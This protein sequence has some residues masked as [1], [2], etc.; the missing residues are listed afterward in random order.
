MAAID[1][2]ET[3]HRNAAPSRGETWWKGVEHLRELG[4]NIPKLDRS[5]AR[6]DEDLPGLL[7]DGLNAGDDVESHP[8]S[9]LPVGQLEHLS[10]HERKRTAKKRSLDWPST[11]EARD[12][13]F[14]TITEVM[15]NEDTA[16][17]DAPTSLGKSHTVATTAWNSDT[18]LNG[19][20]GGRP[21]I[22]LQA[23]RDA[24]DEAIEAAADADVDSFVLQSRHEACPVAAGDYDP[25]EDG[26]DIDY[27]PLT[28][29]G[30]PASEWIE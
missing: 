5:A 14:A 11:R 2:G 27:T 16:V 30:M 25:P 7:E 1:V 20:T 26:E 10:Y 8:V 24:R 29:D 21:V 12:Q 22:H 18:S 17:V 19:I 28:M 4:F 15:R 6:D 9:S 3:S 23:T 13:L